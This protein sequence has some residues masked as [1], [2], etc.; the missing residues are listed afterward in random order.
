MII[1]C[2]LVVYGVNSSY[3]AISWARHLIL[4][5]ISV[6]LGAV[7]LYAIAGSVRDLIFYTR[8]S[9]CGRPL[10]ELSRANLRAFGQ[11]AIPW[12]QHLRNKDFLD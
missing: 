10:L 3:Q 5:G 11:I 8:L 6:L 9:P 12:E 1:A 2:V 4:T 7:G